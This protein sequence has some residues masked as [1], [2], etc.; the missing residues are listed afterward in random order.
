MVLRKTVDV[1]F[2]VLVTESTNPNGMKT[3]AVQEEI[4]VVAGDDVRQIDVKQILLELNNDGQEERR[5][6][7]VIK[8]K[9]SEIYKHARENDKHLWAH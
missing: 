9:E 5:S 4:T 2:R 8:L 3:L 7:T 6:F 1:Q